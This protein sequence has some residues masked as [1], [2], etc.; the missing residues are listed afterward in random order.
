MGVGVVGWQQGGFRLLLL[1]LAVAVLLL[2]RSCWRPMQNIY[3]HDKGINKTS[4]QRRPQAQPAP[5]TNNLIPLVARA[6]NVANGDR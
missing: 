2:L 1:L 4:A 6:L 3:Q 5:N